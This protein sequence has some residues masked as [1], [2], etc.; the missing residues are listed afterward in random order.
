MTHL[1]VMGVAGSG[2]S[3]IG[4]LAASMLG[5]PYF[6]GDDYHGPA[7]VAKMTAG[8]A[9]TDDD[10]WPW[11]DR[12]NAAIAR[13]GDRSV[14][15]ASCLRQAYRDRI[16]RGLDV[17]F[18]WAHGDKALVA[19]RMADRPG[20]FFDPRLNDSQFAIL[21][22]PANA[23]VLDIRRPAEDLARACVDWMR[24]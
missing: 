16:G 18:A 7:N 20:H 8:M 3:T 2:K 10:R 9:L 15:A 24:S 21:E 14:S 6:D 23:L 11:L 17:R 5:W 19:Q 4:R 1:I 22:P 12:M 13:C